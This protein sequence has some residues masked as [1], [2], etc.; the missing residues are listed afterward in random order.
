MIA[1]RTPQQLRIQAE[2]IVAQQET[3]VQNQIA[4]ATTATSRFS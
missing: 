2:N 3:D 1:I 4:N